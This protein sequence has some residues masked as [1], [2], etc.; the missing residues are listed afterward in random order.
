M[1]AKTTGPETP[2]FDK[3]T[4][5]DMAAEQHKRLRML[6]LTEDLTMS[7]LLRAAIEGMLDDEKFRNEVLSRARGGKQ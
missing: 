3:T 4:T 1:S 7:D 6:A 2:K 5:L